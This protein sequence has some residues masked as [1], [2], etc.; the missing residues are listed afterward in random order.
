MERERQEQSRIVDDT[1]RGIGD[2]CAA[3]SRGGVVLGVAAYGLW[4]LIPLYFKAVAHVAPPEVLAHRAWWSFVVL[5]LLAWR[6]GRWREIVG[7]LREPRVVVL[8]S[9]SS[10]LIAVNWLAF[11]YAVQTRQVVQAS[12]GYFINP[13]LSVLLGVTFLGERMRPLQRLSV[14]LALVGVAVLTRLV[15]QFPWLALLLAGTF[16]LYGLLRKVMPV[17]SLAGLTVE[18]LALAPLALGYLGYL[19][20]TGTN[21]GGGAPTVA[22]LMASG[23][24]TTVPLLAFGGAA[25]RL[26][27]ATLG[28]LQYL[29]PTLQFLLAVAAFGEPFSRAQLLSFACIWTAVAVYAFD[30]LRRQFTQRVEVVEPD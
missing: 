12:L 17:D 5:G 8:L 1:M 18:T 22:L 27:L 7:R 26:R 28:I 30:S 3:R 10:C 11:I 19:Y 4:G 29:T 16:A 6:L 14:L 20:A 15:G 25:R 13:L 9:V 23:V 21:T 24:I 2:Q